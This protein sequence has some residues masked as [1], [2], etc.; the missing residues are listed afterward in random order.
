MDTII[1]RQRFWGSLE[2]SLH[3]QL[4]VYGAISVFVGPLNGHR[5]S[6]AMK[7]M[8]HLS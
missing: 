8:A 6:A 7:T 5:L 2:K 1:S 4:R 3:P